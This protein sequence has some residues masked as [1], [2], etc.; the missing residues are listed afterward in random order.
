MPENMKEPE[1]FEV[2]PF[3]IP[4]STRAVM[5]SIIMLGSEIDDL[6]TVAI[7]KL[8]KIDPITAAAII[9]QMPISAKIK[10]LDFFMKN[11]AGNTKE[12]FDKTIRN[13]INIFVEHRN[14][15]AHGVYVGAIDDCLC[16]FTTNRMDALNDE[17]AVFVA[18]RIKIQKLKQLVQLGQRI[19]AHMRE[20]FTIGPLHERYPYTLHREKFDHAAYRNRS[21]HL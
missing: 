14:A 2:Q 7:S 4:K 6:V 10:K 17:I 21:S 9:S 1:V 16:F 12:K 8:A 13:D 3:E 18:A 19:V 11:D 20:A 15:I 5:A